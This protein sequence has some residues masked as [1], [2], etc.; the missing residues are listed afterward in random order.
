MAR[1]KRGRDVH[2]VVLLDKP[3]GLSSNQAL[4]KVRRLFDARKAGHTGSLDPF[5]TG[6]LP[7]CLGEASKTAAFML[8]ADKIY[9]A[10]MVLGAATA[11]GDTEGDVV[12]RAMVPEIG[13][14]AVRRIQRRFTGRIEQVPPMYS[15]LKHRGTPLYRLAREGREVERKPRPVTIHRLELLGWNPPHLEFEVQC[16]KGT[17]VRTLAE[18]IG[19]AL[20]SCAHLDALRRLAV[21]P[22]EPDLMESLEALEAAA[23]D[24]SLES[25][26]LPVDAGLPN[27]PAVLLDGQAAGGFRHGNPQRT[28]AVETG[29]VRVYGPGS[30]LLGLGELG[31]DGT[32]RAR[33]VFNLPDPSENGS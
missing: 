32:L 25:H 10:R 31:A 7:V 6:M 33:R 19:L 27:W 18:D 21:G 8:D 15:A 1:R 17:Y 3:A 24:G 26:L 28:T 30:V 23:E 4:Q 2:G 5:A 20:G 16:S 22:F 9:R 14:D 29:L 13:T 11:T 12:K